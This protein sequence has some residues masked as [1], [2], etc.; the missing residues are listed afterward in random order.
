MVS[1]LKKRQSNRR[2]LS[3]L[4]DFDQDVFIGNAMNNRQEDTTTNKGTADQEFTV[5]NSDSSQA[6]NENLVNV[7]TSERLT[8]KLVMLARSKTGFRTRF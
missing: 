6:V 5:G 7:K 2:L 4:D 3:Q 1:T 8:V